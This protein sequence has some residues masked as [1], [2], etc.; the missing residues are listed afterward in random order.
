MAN[1]CTKITFVFRNRNNFIFPSPS[2]LCFEIVTERQ[3]KIRNKVSIYNRM[4][5]C[6]D[7][8]SAAAA[9]DAKSLQSCLTL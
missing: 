3:P 5:D 8:A 9:A 7:H 4:V 2:H 6:L 1:L